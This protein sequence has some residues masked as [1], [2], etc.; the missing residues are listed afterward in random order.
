VNRK[1]TCLFAALLA[2]SAGVIAGQQTA[3]PKPAATID[4]LRQAARLLP[5]RRPLRINV[6]KFAES[7]RT[8][9]F[10]VKGVPAEPSAHRVSGGVYGRNHH[11]RRGH[12][13]AGS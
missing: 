8:K 6:V 11:D 7:R 5:G 1:T 2:G 3:Q 12:G 10:S 4:E 13:P 9:N